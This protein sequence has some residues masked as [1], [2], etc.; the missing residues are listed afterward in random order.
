MREKKLVLFLFI[1]YVFGLCKGESK[2]RRK[3][4]LRQHADQWMTQAE[5]IKQ[6]LAAKKCT[7]V[8]E[9]QQQEDETETSLFKTGTNTDSSRHIIFLIFFAGLL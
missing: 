2:G 3:D 5:R 9:Q 8:E 4:L 6:Y 1:F 7:D